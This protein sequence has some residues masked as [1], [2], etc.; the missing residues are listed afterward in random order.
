[1][2]GFGKPDMTA[3]R[4]V[5]EPCCNA[6]AMTGYR[7]LTLRKCDGEGRV[8]VVRKDGEYVES[9]NVDAIATASELQRLLDRL[10]EGD[11]LAV[12]CEACSRVR[13]SD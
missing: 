9:I 1:M 11:G 3:I 8:W 13:A 5:F 6:G 12:E 4:E 7:G 10:A 2:V